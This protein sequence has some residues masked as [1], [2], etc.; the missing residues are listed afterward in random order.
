ME[1]IKPEKQRLKRTTFFFVLCPALHVLKCSPAAPSAHFLHTQKSCTFEG[2]GG[3]FLWLF[4]MFGKTVE[5]KWECFTEKVTRNKEREQEGCENSVPVEWIVLETCCLLDN[6]LPQTQLFTWICNAPLCASTVQSAI[7]GRLLFRA[8][9]NYISHNKICCFLFLT[10]SN[11]TV[12]EHWEW[13]Q[14][15]YLQ[16]SVTLYRRTFLAQLKT[17]P[18]ISCRKCVPLP[19]IV[20][21]S[22]THLIYL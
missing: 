9:H 18:K 1:H 13:R 2:V 11:N 6:S 14:Y 4:L 12:Q 21:N 3:R 20:K 16:N 8:L 15:S 7:L 10:V 5:R 19:A 17:M 22:N